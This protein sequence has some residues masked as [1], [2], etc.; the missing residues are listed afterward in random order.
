MPGLPLDQTST[1]LEHSSSA[2]HTFQERGIDCRDARAS[3]QGCC[4]A[5][6]LIAERELKL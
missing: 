4:C 3:L 1:T 5:L 6:R 2:A